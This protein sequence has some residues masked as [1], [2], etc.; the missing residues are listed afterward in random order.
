VEGI[1]AVD[2]LNGTTIEIVKAF[3][4]LVWPRANSEGPLQSADGSSA[5]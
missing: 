4:R 1:R 2:R 5:V 3:Y